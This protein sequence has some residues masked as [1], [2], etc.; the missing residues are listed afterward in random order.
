MAQAQFQAPPLLLRDARETLY[1][2]DRDDQIQA[3]NAGHPVHQ[4]RG[5]GEALVGWGTLEA[6][7]KGPIFVIAVFASIVR[8]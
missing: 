5:A 4:H 8:W 7:L 3:S 1:T 2:R 6:N